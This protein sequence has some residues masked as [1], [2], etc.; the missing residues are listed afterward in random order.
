MKKTKMMAT[1]TMLTTVAAMATGVLAT[2]FGP[3]DP[4]Y[5]GGRW[6][7]DGNETGRMDEGGALFRLY[8]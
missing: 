4:G 3:D 7:I 2:E 1:F 6:W 5:L 8:L